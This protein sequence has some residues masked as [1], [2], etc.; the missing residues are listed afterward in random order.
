MKKLILPLLFV[1]VL[2]LGAKVAS[3]QN[4]TR[5]HFKRGATSALVT[6]H[7]SGFGGRKVYLLKVRRGQ[8][9]RVANASNRHI[10]ISIRDPRGS[11]VGDSDASCNDHKRAY[12]TR[13]GDYRIVVTECRKADPWRGRFRF[14]VSV[15]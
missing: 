5:I 12:P 8:R 7:L 13:A 15:R 6:G 3:A 11:D 14:R 2:F 1:T 9:L 4:P 10:T